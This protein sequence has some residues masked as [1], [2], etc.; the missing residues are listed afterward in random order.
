MN[1]KHLYINVSTL[2]SE[3][4][5]LKPSLSYVEHM[6]FSYQTFHVLCGIGNYICKQGNWGLGLS[7]MGRIECCDFSLSFSVSLSLFLFHS[8]SLDNDST[9]LHLG[10]KTM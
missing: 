5:G 2:E 3:L 8:F 6:P 10:V 1:Q 9:Y 4:D 7:K